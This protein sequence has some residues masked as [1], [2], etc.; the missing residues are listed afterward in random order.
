MMHSIDGCLVIPGGVRSP[1]LRHRA[2]FNASWACWKGV[3]IRRQ[4][5]FSGRLR[6]RWLEQAAGFHLEVAVDDIDREVLGRGE[7]AVNAILSQ[8]VDD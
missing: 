7:Q 3:S 2:S 6:A 8:C 1:F 4:E 5:V